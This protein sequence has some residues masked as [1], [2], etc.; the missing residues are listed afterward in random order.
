MQCWTVLDIAPTTDEKTIRRAYA[1]KLKVIRPDEDAMGYQILREAY[2]E[3]LNYATY[4]CEELESNTLLEEEQAGENTA[5]FTYHDEYTENQSDFTACETENTFSELTILDENEDISGNDDNI[6]YSGEFIFNQIY[7]LYKE[8]GEYGL[9]EEWES[10]KEHLLS[11]I[12]FGEQTLLSLNLF[13]FLKNNV[14]HPIIWKQ[15]S[16]YFNWLGDYQTSSYLNTED[17]EY[18][19][20]K[21]TEANQYLWGDKNYDITDVEIKSHYFPITQALV[22]YVK[23]GGGRFIALCYAMLITPSITQECTKNLRY[24]LMGRNSIVDFIYEYAFMIRFLWRVGLFSSFV[25]IF[26]DQNNLIKLLILMVIYSIV[27]FLGGILVLAVKSYLAKIFMPLYREKML[28]SFNIFSGFLLPIIIVGLLFLETPK[29]TPLIIF[30]LWLISYTTYFNRF[31]DKIMGASLALLGFMTFP[32]FSTTSISIV[33]ALLWLNANLFLERYFPIITEGYL[34]MKSVFWW[35]FF[36]P[37]RAGNFI[38]RSHDYAALIEIGVIA[39]MVVSFLQKYIEQSYL[40]FYPSI[41]LVYLGY[42]GIR[43]WVFKRLKLVQE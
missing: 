12:K 21:Q 3:A 30:L 36:I 34:K 16:E 28:L 20:Q 6:L 14:E 26:Y 42:Q 17:L 43:M 9:L 27:I 31:N 5:F 24:H 25:F 23:N 33:V 37:L 15:W 7:D 39:M 1:K 29:I 4:V 40:L 22:N 8:K 10:I 41:F 11:Q 19:S 13:I 32:K 35:F 38:D 2:E 18:I